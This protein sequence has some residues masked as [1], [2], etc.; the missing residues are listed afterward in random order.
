MEK[1]ITVTF[2]Y[3]QLL[4][5]TL[6]RGN[7]YHVHVRLT[8]TVQSVGPVGT[9]RTVLKHDTIPR[10]SAGGIAREQACNMDMTR[11]MRPFLSA[12]FW[13]EAAAFELK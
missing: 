11:P 9:L 8:P 4:S 3:L 13:Q 5:G 10:P 7:P 2:L 6:T 1:D 12:I